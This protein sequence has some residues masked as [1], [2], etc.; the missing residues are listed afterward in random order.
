MHKSK[1]NRDTK[2]KEIAWFKM[3]LDKKVIVCCF[4]FFLWF[5]LLL[6][7]CLYNSLSWLLWLAW[8]K[9]RIILRSKYNNST[10]TWKC[11]ENKRLE[12]SFQSNKTVRSQITYKN[13]NVCIWKLGHFLNKNIL[14]Q[15]MLMDHK[16]G[17]RLN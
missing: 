14:F 10:V 17:L 12:Q 7:H 4:C 8:T 15:L 1:R 16:S 2:I 6:L 11:F 5:L 13:L 3:S 9:K